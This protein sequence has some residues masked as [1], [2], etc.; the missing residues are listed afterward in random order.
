MRFDLRYPI[1][2]L[3]AGLLSKLSL[4]KQMTP[5]FGQVLPMAASGIGSVWVK[6]ITFECIFKKNYACAL[7][8]CLLSSGAVTA[9]RR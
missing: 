2:A 8:A 6:I 9:M 1:R 3:S 4:S 7:V 5:L